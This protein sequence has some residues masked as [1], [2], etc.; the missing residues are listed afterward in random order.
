MYQLGRE[1]E[2]K[3]QAHRRE[4][5]SPSEARPFAE[6]Q[7]Q[8]AAHIAAAAPA[9]PETARSHRAPI[10]P[11]AP[12][13]PEPPAHAK[14]APSCTLLLPPAS[15]PIRTALARAADGAHRIECVGAAAYKH[16]A[17]AAEKLGLC[18]RLRAEL[19]AD[20]CA[21]VRERRR[22]RRCSSRSSKYADGSVVVYPAV[23]WWG[24]SHEEKRRAGQAARGAGA[25]VRACACGRGGGSGRRA[26]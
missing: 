16:G 23:G 9:D 13:G 26:D 11:V 10:L 20:E 19:A 12:S 6:L 24:V 25:R 3:A 21:E 7:P 1:S 4:R 2:P 15:R 17:H 18:A 14:Q 5:C 8:P 22:E